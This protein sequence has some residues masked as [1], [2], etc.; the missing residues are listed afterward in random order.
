[1]DDE[2]AGADRQLG[3]EAGGKT[4]EQRRVS[5][6]KV[7]GKIKDLIHRGHVRRIINNMERPL[8]LAPVTVL[9]LACGGGGD[10][11][12]PSD[13]TGPDVDDTAGPPPIDTLPPVDLALPV[14][15][16]ALLEGAIVNPFGIVRSSLDLD[17]VGHPGIDLV[18]ARGTAI[19]AVG[20][21][22]I[23]TVAAATDGFPGDAVRLLL[24]TDAPEGEGWVFLY[25]HISLLAGLDV[26]ST[27]TRGE[28]IATNP[29]D[30]GRSNH[31][32]LA[33]VFNNFLF[34]RDQRCWVVQLEPEE[35]TA[36]EDRFN[37]VL[38]V[39]ADFVGVWSQVDFNEGRLP[40]KELLNFTTYPD[41]PR[42]CYTKG[43]DVRVPATTPSTMNR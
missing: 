11:S 1:M 5:G 3:V 40:F 26:G 6:D 33:W 22:V 28:Q 16:A 37:D 9:F 23:V 27:V 42:L 34:H 7:I 8:A 18:S 17:E 29:L 2:T 31:L 41:G 39:H 10:G 12:P 35:R 36:L 38:R 13:L 25:E 21:G 32:E 14:P 20:D 24:S 4:K 19:H 43:T 30:I 15:A